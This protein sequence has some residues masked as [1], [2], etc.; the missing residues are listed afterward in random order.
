MYI[1]I[2]N[3][4]NFSLFLV[5]KPEYVI[6]PCIVFRRYIAYCLPAL[7]CNQPIYKQLMLRRLFFYLILNK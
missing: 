7:A 5:K 4:R 2:N 3:I 1:A 6:C